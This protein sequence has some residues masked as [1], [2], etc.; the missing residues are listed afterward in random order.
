MSL[1]VLEV[2]TLYAVVIGKDV[3]CVRSYSVT[4]SFSVVWQTKA[5]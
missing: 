4:L 1:F 3:L 2:V 5:W